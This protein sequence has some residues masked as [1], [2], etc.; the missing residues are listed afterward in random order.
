MNLNKQKKYWN[1]WHHVCKKLEDLACIVQNPWDDFPLTKEDISGFWEKSRDCL[2][3]LGEMRK[4]ITQEFYRKEEEN[5][6]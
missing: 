2:A 4:E 3:D 5:A 6:E 1:R